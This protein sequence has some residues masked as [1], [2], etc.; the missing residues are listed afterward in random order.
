MH[1]IS[2]SIRLNCR[3]L[4]C[5]CFE[6]TD[7]FRNHYLYESYQ[8]GGCRSLFFQIPVASDFQGVRVHIR[9]L[10]PS[11]LCPIEFPL[12]GQLCSGPALH[13]GFYL[14]LHLVSAISFPV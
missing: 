3:E 7:I 13:G 4:G 12:T 5:C 8:S 2:K 14:A 9:S 1:V 6:W 11:H 10:L